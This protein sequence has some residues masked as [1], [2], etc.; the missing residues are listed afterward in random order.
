MTFD[1]NEIIS[2]PDCQGVV[3]N[4]GIAEIVGRQP[5]NPDCEEIKLVFGEF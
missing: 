5:R 2:P 1:I 4:P 3:S